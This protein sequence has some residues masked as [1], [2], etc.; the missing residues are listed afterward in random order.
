[1]G[2]I[3][4]TPVDPEDLI[5]RFLLHHRKDPAA[6][7]KPQADKLENPF[8]PFGFFGKGRPVNREASPFGYPAFQLVH[9]LKRLFLGNTGR[10]VLAEQLQRAFRLRLKPYVFMAQTA[11]PG[12]EKKIEGYLESIW[13]DGMAK[14][15]EKI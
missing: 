1:M 5:N 9:N 7:G 13:T 3:S 14:A 10:P 11:V 2:L 4:H 12:L 8:R 15:I 6:I